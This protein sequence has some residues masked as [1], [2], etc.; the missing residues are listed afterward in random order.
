MTK[1][2]TSFRCFASRFKL[3]A[4]LLALFLSGFLFAAGTCAW[5]YGHAI[6]NI[7][8][9]RDR[10][11]L[12][13]RGDLMDARGVNRKMLEHLT[14]QVGVAISILKEATVNAR[15]AAVTA[16]KAARNANDAAT[17]AANAN[18]HIRSVPPPKTHK[19]T[20]KHWIEH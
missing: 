14:E 11:V 3:I 4:A 16:D 15:S 9:A 18:I 6:D 5:Y 1:L 7:N 20:N 19:R 12:A 13:L 10:Q 8:A 2:L 17:N